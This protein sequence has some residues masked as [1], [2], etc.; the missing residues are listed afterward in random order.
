MNKDFSAN[1]KLDYH[2]WYQDTPDEGFSPE[3]NKAVIRD[4]I[5]KSQLFRERR[6]KDYVESIR[7]RAD[8]VA[9]YLKAV[10][11]GMEKGVDQYFGRK[12]LARLR[13][14]QIVEE[15]KGRMKRLMSLD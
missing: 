14:K 8:A 6:N 1:E 10:A 12:E 3:R 7:E 2:K 9:S 13:G 11:M 15:V 5:A 4:S